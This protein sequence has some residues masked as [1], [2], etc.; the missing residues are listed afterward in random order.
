[1]ADF[2]R[3]QF[4][5]AGAGTCVTLGTPFLVHGC[6]D[7]EEKR[8][9]GSAQATVR[10][11]LGD[12][13]SDLYRMGRQ[14]AE[15]LGLHARNDLSGKAVFIKPNFVVFGTGVPVAP[16]TGE[17]TKAEIVVGVAEQCLLA[18]AE[19]VSIGD[20]SQGVDWDWNGVVFF[21]G[22]TVLGRRNLKQVVDSLKVRFP[23]QHVEL[24]CLNAVNEWEHIPSSSDHEMMLSGLKIARSFFEAD[25]V[26]SVPVLKTHSLA[27]MTCSMK[28][29]VGVTPSLPPYGKYADAVIRS[30]LHRAY[31]RAASAGIEQAGIAACFTDIVKW[32]KQAGR[33]DYAI[34]DCSIGIEA[35]GPS[36]V[37]GGKT[38]DMRERS[39]AGKYFLIA[40]NDLPAADAT[41]ARVMGFD[42]VSLKQLRIA[43]ELGLGE[44]RNIRVIGD[45]TLEEIRIPDFVPAEQFAEWAPSATMLPGCKGA[46]Q[47]ETSHA[48]NA[49]GAF[50]LAAG[51]ILLN[52]Q[53]S[54]RRKAK[55]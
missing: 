19:K 33:Q 20:G 8:H 25:H 36:L 39:R 14:A 38:I 49:L 1:M 48:A 17:W 28:N 26:I 27:E 29:Y 23:R 5:K 43:E 45:A 7:D 44:I 47:E 21:E 37:T 13:P 40:S 35:D 42:A 52:S 15:A 50:G 4:L 41:A 54:N 55:E 3:R 34:V 10:I 31:A 6:G 11:V 12:G 53:L 51:S 16:L 22:N 9:A 24:L 32:R 46:V 30:E 2:T 18:G